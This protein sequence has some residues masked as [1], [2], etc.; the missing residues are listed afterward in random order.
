VEKAT[1]MDC[2]MREVMTSDKIR[3]C[4]V[5]RHCDTG[6]YDEGGLQAGGKMLF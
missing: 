5:L 2:K 4:W 3:H 1:G 6:E